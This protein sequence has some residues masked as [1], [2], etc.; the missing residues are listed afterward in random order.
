M[1][2]ALTDSELPVARVCAFW[3]TLSPATLSNLRAVYDEH[4]H[5]PIRSTTCTARTPCIPC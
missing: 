4:I 1:A 3:Q 5:F 2:D